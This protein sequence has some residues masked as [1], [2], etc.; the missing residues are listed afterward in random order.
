MIDWLNENW[1]PFFVAIAGLIKLVL[2]PI[3]GLFTNLSPLVIIVLL[4]YAGYK[5]GGWRMTGFT[6][7]ALLVVA[8]MGFWAQAMITM[9]LVV[10]AALFALVIGVPLG[11]MKF[12]FPKFA[13]VLDP[14]LDFMQ[15]MPL[16]VYL[17]PAVLFFSIG[18]VPGIVAT[19]IFATPPA[20]RLT[21]LGFEQIPHELLEVGRAFGASRRQMLVKVELPLALPSILMGMNQTIMLSLS[22]VVVASMIGAEGLG[23]EVLRGITRLKVG[24]GIAGGLGIVLLAMILD[25]L[26]RQIWT[27]RS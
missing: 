6:A 3:T 14:L 13:M 22:M 18:N 26:T 25:R 21:A 16:F 10:T 23:Q 8:S 5:L 17:I 27:K 4:S 2:N 12:H 1:D 7:A 9:S 15:T 11:V 20:V 24:Q 19:F